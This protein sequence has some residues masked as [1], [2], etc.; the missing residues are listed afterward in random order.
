MV[1]GRWKAVAAAIGAVVVLAVVWPSLSGEDGGPGE[2]EPASAA[3][4]IANIGAFLEKCPASDPAYAQIRADFEIRREGVVVGAID[5]S[6]PISDMEIADYTDELIALQTLRTVYWM[7]GGRSVPY[8]WTAGNL[9]DWFKSRIGGIDIRANGSYCCESYNGKW[10]IVVDTLGNL[11]R[12][13]ARGWRGISDQMTLVAHETRHVD[14]FGHVGGCPMFPTQGFGCDQTYNENSLSAYGLEW[15]LNAKWL[16]GEINVG[17][18]CLPEQESIPIS[19]SHLNRANN[20]YRLRFVNSAP[21]SLSMPAQPGGACPG[22][23]T[24]TTA[25]TSTPA[26]TPQPTASPTPSPPPTIPPTPAPT[27]TASPTPTAAVTASPTSVPTQPPALI[28]GDVDC[29]GSVSA[30]DALKVMRF[31]SH[32]AFSQNEPCPDIGAASSWGDVEC[33]GA[34]NSVDA[35]KIL[36]HVTGMQVVQ[37]EPCPNIGSVLP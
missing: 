19:N 28:Q 31:V 36:Q 26:P 5:C 9:Y 33:N 32:L 10:Y 23:P 20:D 14:G 4:G 3:G 11:D 18:A 30:A 6:E 34:V 16:S 24:P 7:E 25:P 1:Y 21:P 13:A 15:W 29:S 35:L 17:F 22:G 27:P 8:P 37:Q 2:A 12:N